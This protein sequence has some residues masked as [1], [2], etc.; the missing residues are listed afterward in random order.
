M[1]LGRALRFIR[2]IYAIFYVISGI[3]IFS[4]LACLTPM[5]EL[6]ISAENAAFQSALHATGFVVPIMATCYVAS[7]LL[8]LFERTAALG[9]VILGPF[10]VVILFTHLMLN[11]RP[12]WGAGHALML[13]IF[14]WQFR[15]SYSLMWNKPTKKAQQNT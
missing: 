2:R 4:F 11:G 12:I 5:P 7:G 9:I 13:G 3:L 14:A 8:M 1:T 10:V 15:A 6:G